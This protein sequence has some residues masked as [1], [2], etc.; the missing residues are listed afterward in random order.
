MAQHERPL[1]LMAS[2]RLFSRARA[3]V[4]K[5]RASE[6][7]RERREDPAKGRNS[8]QNRPAMSPQ[9]LRP[10]IPHEPWEFAY[11]AKLTA[12]HV[13]LA[14]EAAAPSRRRRLLPWTILPGDTGLWPVRSVLR[15]GS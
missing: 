12:L 4:A 5:A 1:Y 14:R 13:R 8:G 7:G 9:S 10:Q 2:N 3:R 11:R 15:L 6:G